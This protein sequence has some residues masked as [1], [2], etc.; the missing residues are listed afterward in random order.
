MLC[1]LELF[2][3]VCLVFVQHRAYEKRLVELPGSIIG[4]GSGASWNPD[5][6]QSLVLSSVAPGETFLAATE[7]ALSY[8]KD[9]F[10]DPVS[11]LL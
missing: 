9:D 3:R 10:V 1:S 6:P 4:G 11:C 2:S 7:T 5:M 8:G